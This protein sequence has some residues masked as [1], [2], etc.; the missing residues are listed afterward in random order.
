L[1]T[2]GFAS[3]SDTYERGRPDYPAALLRALADEWGLGPGCRAVD[4]AAGTGKLTRQLQAAGAHCL[5]LEPSAAM[6]AQ[7]RA[8]SPGMAVAGSSAEAIPLRD[9]S[10]DLL[11]VAQAFH[12]FEAPVALHEMARVLRPGG[13]LVLVWNERDTTSEWTGALD[14]LLG[15]AGGSPHRPAEALRAVFDGDPH[16]GPFTRWSGPHEVAMTAA[17]V[18]DLVASRSYVRVLPTAER[19]VVLTR[20]RALVDPLPPP[21][22]LPYVTN[23]YCARARPGPCACAGEVSWSG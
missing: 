18:A 20:V 13:V 19:D 7:C 8:T 14:Q 15:Q 1:G 4:L 6:R 12:W 5:A 22:L 21:L 3:G 23:A 17:E 16:F 9:N 10:V 2:A 11:T